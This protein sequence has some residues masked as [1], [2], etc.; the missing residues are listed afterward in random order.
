MSTYSDTWIER[1][2]DLLISVSGLRGTIPRGLC[3]ENIVP[4]IRAFAQVT[5]KVIVV[6]RD[7]RPSG[8]FI[9]QLIVGTLVAAGKQVVDIGVAPTP[10]VKCVVKARQAD[11]G[12]MISASHNPLNWNG[13]KFIDRDGLFFGEA[14]QKSW[15]DALQA[16]QS[17]ARA[18][19]SSAYV[20]TESLGTYQN[21]SSLDV[22]IDCVLQA[23]PQLDAIAKKKYLVVVDGVYGAG[24]TAL[25]KLLEKLGCQ[26]IPLYCDTKPIKKFP[27]PPE[28]NQDAIQN[29]AKLVKKHK[30]A[31]GF[32]LDPDSDRLALASAFRGPIHEEY[33]LV[34]AMLGLEPLLKR[35][36]AAG[37]D[38]HLVVNLSTALLCDHLGAAH[39]IKVFRSP[40]GEANVVAMMQKKKACFGGEG[41]GGVILP[42]VPSYG[43]DPLVGAALILSAMALQDAAS[44][45]TLMDTLPPL[46]MHKSKHRMKRNSFQDVFERFL[47]EFPV[48]RP[49]YRDGLYL[50]IDQQSWL[51]LRSSNTE[52]VIRLIAEAPDAPRLKDIV[53]RSQKLIRKYL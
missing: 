3:P 36:L 37:Q 33:T 10:T 4:F 39:K 43:R 16:D 52:P 17:L 38:N 29:L 1:G 45:D 53:T 42:D 15:L 22:H 7:T 28:P 41:N 32:A 30:A 51:H 5:A 6:G 21:F 47:L 2:E 19:K 34:L 14:K 18:P 9:H 8:S 12:I 25:P 44:V 46:F 31:V 40:V 48:P 26:V 35:R 11:A 20:N 50:S 49:D 23:L 27:R 13:F 24:S